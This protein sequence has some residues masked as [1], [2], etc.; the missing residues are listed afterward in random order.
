MSSRTFTGGEPLRIH[1]MEALRG[2]MFVN[3]IAIA[4]RFRIL[5]YMR[6]SGLLKKYSIEKMLLELH[7]L[8]KVILNGGKEITTEITRK[9]KEI[10][11]NRESVYTTVISQYELLAPVYHKGM[12]G[13]ERNIR[14]FLHGLKSLNFLGDLWKFR[15]SNYSC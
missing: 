7:K 10:E 9:Q 11:S 3:L 12:K 13:E 15:S 4:I 5:E 8:R 6:S 14:A 1:G 2:E